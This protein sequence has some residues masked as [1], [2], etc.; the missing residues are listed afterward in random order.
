MRC[1][2]HDVKDVTAAMPLFPLTLCTSL[3]LLPLLSP[4][5]YPSF[6]PNLIELLTNPQRMHLIISTVAHSAAQQLT[7]ITVIAR[8]IASTCH[9]P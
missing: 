1:G 6:S 7:R 3:F 4:A 5:T 2:S 8:V 9:A